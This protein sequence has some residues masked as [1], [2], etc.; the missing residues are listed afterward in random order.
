MTQSG[1][2]D[3]NGL[4]ADAKKLGMTDQQIYSE[5]QKTQQFSAITKEAK[6]SL[7]MSDAQIASQF[8]LNISAPPAATKPQKDLGTQPTMTFQA[9]APSPLVKVG[10]GAAKAWGGIMQGIH[11][12]GDTVQSAAN[13]TFGTN[14][15]TGE[16]KKFT[17]GMKEGERLYQKGRADNGQTGFDG[18]SF[19]GELGAGAPA[20]L[21]GTGRTLLGAGVRGAIGGAGIGAAQF[22]EDGGQRLKNTGAGALGGLIGGAAGKSLERVVSKAVNAKKGNYK[23]EVKEVLDQG[24]KHNVRVSAGDATQ[25]PAISK[26]EVLMEQV[27]VVGTAGFRKAQ[28][29]EAEVAAHKVVDALH[30]KLSDVDY[31]SL[32]KIQAAASNGDKNAMRIMGVVNNA[33]DDAGKI[34]QAS[35]EIK[36]WRGQQ[37]ASQ[38]FDRVNQIAG[39]NKVTPNKTIQAID[40]VIA[41]DSKVVPNTEMLKEIGGIQQKLTDPIVNTSFREMQAAR[42]RLGEL[43]DEWGRQGKSTS[44]LTKIRTAIDSDLADFANNSGNQSLMREY[45][46]ANLF[47]KQLQGGKDKALANSMRSQTPDEIYNQFVKVGKG[48]RAANFYKSLDPKG[49]AALRYEMANQAIIKASKAKDV[50][51]PATFAHEFERLNAPYSQIFTGNHKAEM[52]GFVKLMRHVERAGQFAENPPTGNRLVP[53]LIGGAAASNIPLAMKAA[54]ASA[55]AKALFTTSAGK[56]ILLASKDLPPNSPKLANLLKQAEKLATVAGASSAQ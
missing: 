3:V 28:Q 16:Y 43:V 14:F 33:G 54:T 56:R 44:A 39:Q 2:L 18:W 10:H 36:N 27:P 5:L 49:Q 22:A 52:D 46:R 15:N 38:M 47:Y 48:D 41:S 19:L 11:K 6:G 51:S 7:R 50:F 21:A 34:L 13:D 37:I 42:S 8:G 40:D 9:E 35:A 30:Q 4:V 1:K 25:N 26:T 55:I 32:N 45:K 23:P 53:L 29:T 31:K 12:V 20:G 17:E 24:A